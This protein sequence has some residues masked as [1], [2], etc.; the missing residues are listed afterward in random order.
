[1]RSALAGLAALG[2]LAAASQVAADPH[3]VRIRAITISER[4][5]RASIGSSPNTAAYMVISN[6]ANVPDKLLSASCA[7]AAKVEIHLSHQMH[8]MMMMDSAAPV[9]IPAHG[10]VSFQPGG[11]HL[12]ITGLKEKLI[13]KGSQDIT[14]VFE[15]AGPVTADFHIRSQIA[16]DGAPP[17]HPR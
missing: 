4:V 8:G 12:M 15:H 17:A 16:A 6:A 5:V 14:L 7:C 13:D 9:L 3:Q 11:L 1:M 10:S 2:V